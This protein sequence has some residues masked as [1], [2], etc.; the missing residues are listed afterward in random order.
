MADLIGRFLRNQPDFGL[1]AGK[2][3]LPVEVFL[4][5]EFVRPHLTH[6]GQTE[7]VTE[8]QAVDRAGRH[9][10][11]LLVSSSGPSPVTGW[12][13]KPNVFEMPSQN[14]WPAL[15][16]RA[17]ASMFTMLV[18]ASRVIFRVLE[19]AS[20]DNAGRPRISPPN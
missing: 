7:D 18:T 15:I 2:R 19:Q 3:R 13:G 6:C 12:L 20:L 14:G 10:K 8:D 17:P 1:G 5:T 11:N 9:G 4:G 16:Y